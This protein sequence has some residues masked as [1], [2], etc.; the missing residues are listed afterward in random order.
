M[1]TGRGREIAHCAV[2][3]THRHPPNDCSCLRVLCD[4]KNSLTDC[5]QGHRDGT[6]PMAGGECLTG[7]YG[8]QVLIL[9]TMWKCRPLSPAQFNRLLTV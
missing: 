5:N 9:S 6:Y 7:G 1:V 3:R 4:S 8:D 2:G